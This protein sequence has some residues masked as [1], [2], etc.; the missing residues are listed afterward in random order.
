MKNV[1]GRIKWIFAVGQLGWSIL[2]GIIANLLVN[3]YLPDSTGEGVITFVTSATFLGLT[4]IGIITACG[5]LVDAVTD[6]WIASLSDNCSS[7][8]GKR[9][10]FMIY[11][12]FIFQERHADKVERIRKAVNKP[13]CTDKFIYAVMD[14]AG[15]RFAD[16]DDVETYSLFR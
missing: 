12:S 9:I 11:V 8:L 16:N 13:F 15:Y 1:P 3:F 6:P 10:P 7:K 5:R 14:V 4:V 2:S